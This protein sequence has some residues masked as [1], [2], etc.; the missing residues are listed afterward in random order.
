MLN[1]MPWFYAG[2]LVLIGLLVGSFLNVVILRLPKSL[3]YQW[4]SQCRELL[5]VE[6]EGTRLDTPP[7]IVFPPS[8]CPECQTPL[9]WWQNLPLVSYILLKGKC[10]SCHKP[11]PLRYPII[12]TLSAGLTLATGFIFPQIEILPWALTLIWLL[13]AMSIIDFDTHLLP[14]VLTLPLM[15][16]GLL[17]SL[18]AGSF[19]TPQDAIIGAVAG[20]MALW[21]LYQAHYFL[22]KK[23]G[24]GYGD[25]KLLAAAGA[26]LGWQKLPFVLLIAAVS[27]LIIALLLMLL[28]NRRVDEP[29]SFGPFLSI[30]FIVTLL[31]GEEIITQYIG[32]LGANI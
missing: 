6:S 26:W 22:T 28:K 29:I 10:H 24:M 32:H 13:I 20:Y 21:L 19:T 7:N 1:Y 3:E 14:D 31:W 12:E 5:E 2:L 25:F 17:F 15:W 4:K 11:I 9:R 18:T 23:H 27:G 30:G 8:H 16:L